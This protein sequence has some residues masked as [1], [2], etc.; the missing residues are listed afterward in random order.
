MP[1]GGRR[2]GAGRKKRVE[3]ERLRALAAQAI[4]DETWIAILT[5]LAEEAQD[6]NVRCAELLMKYAFGVTAAAAKDSRRPAQ[7]APKK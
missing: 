7:P 1:H 5:G 2:Q 6:G 3:I 4:G